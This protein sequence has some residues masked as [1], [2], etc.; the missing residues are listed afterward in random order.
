ML[1]TTGYVLEGGRVAL[2][3]F[4]GERPEPVITSAWAEIAAA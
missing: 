4:A 3:A 1:R 2:E